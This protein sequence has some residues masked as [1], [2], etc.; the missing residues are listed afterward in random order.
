MSS[1]LERIYQ[2]NWLIRSG[3][4]PSVKTFRE[5]F[6]VRERTIYEDL[7][8][9]RNRL[10]APL[11]Y[12]RRYG[13]YYYTDPTWD[14]PNIQVSEGE[15]LAFFLSVELA[16]RYLG[17]SFE[18]P[19][20]NAVAK[21][22]QSLP[23]QVQLDF[24][25]LMQH[26]TFQPGATAS[27]DPLLLTALH[28]AIHEC[29]RVE[30]VYYTAS[31]GE[32]NR[33]VIEPHHLYN[34]RGEWQVIAFDHLRQQFRNF[35]AGRI[36]EWRLL[37]DERF[38]RNPDFSPE[39][40]LAHGFLAERGEQPMEVVIWFDEYQARYI[41]E[42]QTHA[43]QQIEEHD[44]GSLTL[45]FQTAALNEVRRWAMSF[46][47]HVEVLAPAGLRAEIA[48]EAAIVARQHA[49]TAELRPHPTQTADIPQ[50]GVVE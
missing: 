7:N 13:G 26:Y 19:L 8:F 28:E 45:R 40:Y 49:E 35:A 3:S 5:R 48:A 4:Y 15:I 25:Q 33:R 47:S 18:E 10:E 17:T 38:S 50:G 43:T 30:M 24:S 44:D 39:R 14:L 12:S 11:K 27:A 16:R 21:L 37:K 46:G 9:L 32:R 20:R 29:W 36:E 2:M 1:K 31:R 42:R 22:A 23:D 6:E 34:V 41:R